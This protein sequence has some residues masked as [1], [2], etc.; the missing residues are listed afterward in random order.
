LDIAID[1]F[2]V[3]ILSTYKNCQKSINNLQCVNYRFLVST[4]DP[5]ILNEKT[6]PTSLDTH[7]DS[8]TGDFWIWLLM[9]WNCGSNLYQNIAQRASTTLVFASELAFPAKLDLIHF[10]SERLII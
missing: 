4:D 1:A 2:W 5:S 10:F 6:D 9:L 7:S 3:A 8:K